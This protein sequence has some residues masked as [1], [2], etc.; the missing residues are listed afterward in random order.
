VLQND[1]PDPIAASEEN[2]CTGPEGTAIERL[3]AEFSIFTTSTALPYPTESE[4]YVETGF[5]GERTGTCAS[6][7]SASMLT[8]CSESVVEEWRA[9]R[10]N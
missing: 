5:V 10:I 8:S 6:N 2:E 3:E 1:G 4:L 7:F 9:L